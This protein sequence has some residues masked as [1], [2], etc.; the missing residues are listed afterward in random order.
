MNLPYPTPGYRD[1]QRI[2]GYQRWPSHSASANMPRLPAGSWAPL[3]AGSGSGWQV[4]KPWW[5]PPA[6]ANWRNPSN[7]GFHA[8]SPKWWQTAS[9]GLSWGARRALA[10][11]WLSFDATMLAWRLFNMMRKAR[12][13]TFGWTLLSQCPGVEP[14][15]SPGAGASQ[16]CGVGVH[17]GAL[18]ISSQIAIRAT[19]V[20]LSTYGAFFW[21]VGNFLCRRSETWTRNLQDTP[22][23]APRILHKQRPHTRPYPFP[24]VDP[25]I[26]PHQ[27]LPDPMPLPWHAIP[28]LRLNPWRAP[29][30]Q[31]ERG[32]SPSPSPV[33]RTEWTFH[34]SMEY[35]PKLRTRPLPR[36]RLRPPRFPRPPKA[37]EKEKK[38]RAFSIAG[39]AIG[40]I[41]SGITESGDF[42]GAVWESI[43]LRYRA[44][45]FDKEGVM[46]PIRVGF[47]QK[48]R[49]IY[50]NWEK[51]RLPDLAKN[52]LLEQAEDFVFGKI[53]GINAAASQQFGN[54]TGRPVGFQFG[55][56]H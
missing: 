28:G 39:S 12:L 4:P 17:V 40:K 43:P 55:H 47:K 32:Y 50:E 56:L 34:P 24:A 20:S 5:N 26:Q 29:G 52:L 10:P 38:V 41:I 48:L 6:G 9:N 37:R 8:A 25:F 42:V 3:P 30:E 1:M 27:N 44:H 21:A 7:F 19:Q 35:N 51:I 22:G 16:L 14:L 45:Y 31:P 49:D 33:G 15:W 23:L 46:R 36:P 18:R 13:R 11:F 53:G 54:M 2:P